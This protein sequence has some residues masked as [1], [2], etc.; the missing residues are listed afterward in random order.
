MVGGG[1]S[2]SLGV[3]ECGLDTLPADPFFNRFGI[4]SPLASDATTEFE[5]RE[6]GCSLEELTQGIFIHP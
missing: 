5:G 3:F 1:V 6:I 4:G 2:V